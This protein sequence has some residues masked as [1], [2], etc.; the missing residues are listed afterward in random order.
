MSVA[1]AEVPVADAL[2]AGADGSLADEAAVALLT[3]CGWLD[4]EDFTSQFTVA[5]EGDT[6]T[7]VI[8]WKSA[9][10]ALEDERLPCSTEDQ[11]I[12]RLAASIANGTPVSL[13]DVIPG[14]GERKANAV[15]QAL[16]S[17]AGLEWMECLI[18]S[19][20][21]LLAMLDNFLRLRPDGFRALVA[22]MESEGMQ[23]PEC[24]ASMAIA[25]LTY[26]TAQCCQ[27]LGRDHESPVARTG[28]RFSF[29]DQA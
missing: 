8:D 1:S 5:T 2:S 7:A 10:A 25:E 15:I 9:I 29:P 22:F 14:F 23:M 24:A 12:L 4:R 28:I 6:P 3:E 11:G 20:V 16:T 26:F 27:M 13:G 18:E 17:M 19:Y 21:G